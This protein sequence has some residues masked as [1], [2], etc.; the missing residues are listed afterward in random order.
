MSGYARPLE[1][2][3]HE[4][5]LRRNSLAGTVRNALLQLERTYA[6]R[7]PDPRA[8]H[9]REALQTAMAALLAP[10]PEAKKLGIEAE[11]NR[12]VRDLALEE[13]RQLTCEELL[14]LAK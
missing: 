5:R 1:T 13:K 14:E 10:A 11:I 12:A 7:S 8:V 9:E 3:L 2:A 6:W 4:A